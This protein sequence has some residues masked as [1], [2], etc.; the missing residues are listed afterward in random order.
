MST[1]LFTRHSTNYTV[2]FRYDPD[3]VELLKTAV[4][5]G[6]RDWNPATKEWTIRA[7]HAEQLASALRS[8]GHKVLGLDPPRSDPPP[9]ADG[10]DTAQW[11]RDLLTRV[12]PSHR[13]PV[14]RALTKVL[15]PDVGGDHRLMQ[16]LNRARDELPPTDGKQP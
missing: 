1:I 13:D 8:T 15:H 12:G 16:D 11:A 3:L 4:P 10:P 9:R 5:S 14:F 7:G 6:A 2:R